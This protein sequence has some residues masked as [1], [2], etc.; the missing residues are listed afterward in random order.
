MGH[1]KVNSQGLEPRIEPESTA[2]TR[3][4]GKEAGT[5]LD[6]FQQQV[7]DLPCC[8]DNFLLSLQLK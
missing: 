2:R 1:A 7:K 8:T 6:L 3:G 4:Q 5:M